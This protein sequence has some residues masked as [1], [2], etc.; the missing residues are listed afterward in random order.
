MT[1][2]RAEEPSRRGRPPRSAEA[3]AEL[4]KVWSKRVER[5]R[6]SGLSAKDFANEIGVEPNQLKYW[7][8]KLR[9]RAGEVTAR[10]PRAKRAPREGADVW[11]E[12]IKR[13][14]TS[15]MSAQAFATELGVSAVTLLNWK[16]KLQRLALAQESGEPSP[17]KAARAKR[18]PKVV[19]QQT[20]GFELVIGNGMTLRV[21]Q[22][23]DEAA[24]SRLVRVRMGL[25]QG[26]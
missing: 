6:D 14:K 23:F 15:G 11:A 24:L 5:W 20:S 17:A 7:T 21:A 4:V 1:M 18:A 2:E 19:Q 22:D 3:E 13:W 12:R 16:G 10:G 26:V 9:K 8:I 25:A